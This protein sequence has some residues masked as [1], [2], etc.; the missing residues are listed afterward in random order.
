MRHAKG[1]M[2]LIMVIYLRFRMR[3]LS[4]GSQVRIL[5]GAPTD[6]R[7]HSALVDRG[8]PAMTGNRHPKLL[9]YCTTAATLTRPPTPAVGLG[10]GGG[11]SV[12]SFTLDCARGARCSKAG[13]VATQI[14]EGLRDGKSK[15]LPY[16]YGTATLVRPQCW[17]QEFR[18]CVRVRELV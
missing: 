16:S 18:P 11:T 4:G 5:P 15:T 13:F 14:H 9:V 1:A 6:Q 17:R 10:G 3:L 2:T 8:I 12:G 7:I